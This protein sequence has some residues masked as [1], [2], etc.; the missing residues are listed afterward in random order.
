MVGTSPT[1]TGSVLF[2]GSGL[3]PEFTLGPTEG[4]TRGACP[5]KTERAR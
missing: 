1:M 2:M 5:G 3:R 4:R